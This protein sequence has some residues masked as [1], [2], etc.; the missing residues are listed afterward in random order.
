MAVDEDRLYQVLRGASRLER[1]Q[2]FLDL[3]ASNDWKQVLAPHV[4]SQVGYTV[5]DELYP[6]CLSFEQAAP[7]IAAD[8]ERIHR[9]LE[10]LGARF[11]DELLFGLARHMGSDFV[12][13]ALVHLRTA[14]GLRAA[15]LMDMLQHADTNWVREPAARRVIRHRLKHQDENR[16]QLML[17]LGD[18]GNLNDFLPEIL[19]YPP[20]FL[21]E[22]SAL[23]RAGIYNEQLVNRALALLGFGPEPMAYLLRLEPVPDAVVPRIVAAAKPDWL[24]ASL[25]VAILE[26]L[27]CRQ[28]VPL[29]ELAVQLGGR[30]LAAAVAWLNS[31]RLG[32]VLLA[33]LA[34][35]MKEQSEQDQDRDRLDNRMWPKR[36]APSASR[37]LEQGRKGHVPDAMDA[38]VLVR[39]LHG[40]KLRETVKEILST[41]RLE[42]M[43]LV[44]RPLC[45]VNPEAALEVLKLSRSTNTEVSQRAKEAQAWPDVAWPEEEPEEEL[46]TFTPLGEGI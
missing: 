16:L 5:N 8:E 29:T 22:W 27:H 31:A 23:G 4:V 6:D 7:L 14:E 20:Q 18:A 37:A 11:A 32:P 25:E 40:E 17:W 36:R 28:M 15:Q 1:R 39:Q 2:A 42:M 44:L 12:E 38:A 43:E 30:H 24:I 26:G 10:L 21:E 13:H 34:E 19:E 46:H 45:A 3:I 35:R 41:P 33:Q 9:S